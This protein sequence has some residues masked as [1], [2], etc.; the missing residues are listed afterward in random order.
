LWISNFFRDLDKLGLV[1]GFKIAAEDIIKQIHKK[2]SSA[3]EVLAPSP[4]SSPTFTNQSL[5]QE[6]ED[7]HN[8]RHCEIC[9]KWNPGDRSHGK[10][11]CKPCLGYQSCPTKWAHGHGIHEPTKRQALAEMK[12]AEKRAYQKE[13]EVPKLQAT[14]TIIKVLLDKLVR[15]D[16]SKYSTLQGTREYA[17]AMKVIINR[18]KSVRG[19]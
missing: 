13:S 12:R 3:V 16:P 4:V 17:A 2:K 14:D 11:K 5:D 8:K 15:Q 1:D 9:H 18:V 6:N 19:T 7:G 10:T